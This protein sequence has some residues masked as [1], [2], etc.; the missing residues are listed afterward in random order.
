MT[1]RLTGVED[2]IVLCHLGVPR[3]GAEPWQI[4]V[5]GL[6][7]HP[8]TFDLAELRQFPYV[9]IEAFHQCAGSPMDP[10]RPTQRVSNVVWG[11][12]PLADV[13][14]SVQPRADARYLWSFGA[15]WGTFEGIAIDAYAKDLPLT[16]IGEDVLLAVDMNGAPLT[17][18]HGF[19][20]RLVVP[21]FYGTNSVKWLTRMTFAAERSDGPFTTRWYSDPVMQDGRPTGRTRPVWSVAPQSVIVDPWPKAQVKQGIPVEIWGWA[22]ADTGIASVAVETD[23]GPIAA[24]VEPRRGRSWQRFVATWRPERAGKQRLGARAVDT[25]GAV[26]PDDGAR[27]AILRVEVVVE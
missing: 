12:Y 26:Q 27:N 17:P 19:P 2:V 15:D 9:E 7:E 18:E 5:D 13:V 14:A 20:V 10:S 24:H 21:G 23:A 3:V 8:R 16:R 25:N 11:G 6:V 1:S 4:V 22:W